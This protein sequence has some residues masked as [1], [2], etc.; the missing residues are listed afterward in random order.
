MYDPLRAQDVLIARLRALH[1]SLIDLTTGRVIRLLG[2]W[3]GR[4][5]GC[6]R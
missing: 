3:G 4:R 6:R 1:P 5:T 2:R